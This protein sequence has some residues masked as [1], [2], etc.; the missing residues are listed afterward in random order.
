MF[1]FFAHR[2]LKLTGRLSSSKQSKTFLKLFLLKKQI[3]W[4][5]YLRKLCRF[6]L[7]FLSF[8]QRFVFSKSLSIFPI[9]QRQKRYIIFFLPLKDLERT[10]QAFTKRLFRSHEQDALSEC[11]FVSCSKRH[12][13][14]VICCFFL[15]KKKHSESLHTNKQKNL[16]FSCV[17][18]VQLLS[19]YCRSV[20]LAVQRSCIIFSFIHSV[21]FKSRERETKFV[22]PN[23]CHYP[24]S[25]LSFFFKNVFKTPNVLLF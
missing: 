4:E 10:F 20:V 13:C 6:F 15:F 7:F 19:F 1:V 17:T 14:E 3:H 18:T 21:L 9:L 8:S 23:R 16:W 5:K 22:L 25:C 11:S 12:V 24:K 2:T